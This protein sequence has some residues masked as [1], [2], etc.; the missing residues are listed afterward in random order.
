[1]RLPN[2]LRRK[3]AQSVV[4]YIVIF[5]V[6][7]AGIVLVFGGFNPD[8][9]VNMKNVFDTAVNSAIANINTND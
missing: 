4:E 9:G 7:V 1:M 8:S 6:L 3:R 5:T 2:N